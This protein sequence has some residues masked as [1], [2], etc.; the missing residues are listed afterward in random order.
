[1][2]E[3]SVFLILNNKVI[4]FFEY[5]LE[6]EQNRSSY[7]FRVIRY[8]HSGFAYAANVRQPETL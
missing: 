5:N 2:R 6:V 7:W 1:M 4:G 3:Y 8:L